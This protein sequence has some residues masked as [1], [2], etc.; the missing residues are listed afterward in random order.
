MDRIFQTWITHAAARDEAKCNSLAAANHESMKH[1]INFGE[2]HLVCTYTRND[3]M[4]TVLNIKFSERFI[5]SLDHADIEVEITTVM[6]A[7]IALFFQSL[8]FSLATLDLCLIAK[9][10]S[11]SSATGAPAPERSRTPRSVQS[12]AVPVVLSRN[13]THV[14]SL[15]HMILSRNGYAVWVRLAGCR[16]HHEMGVKPA[17]GR[18]RATGGRPNPEWFDRR[19]A[20]CASCV[21]QI[22]E[23]RLRR[24]RVR[25][26][27]GRSRTVATGPPRGH[28]HHDPLVVVDRHPVPARGGGPAVD[29]EP[30]RL[31]PVDDDLR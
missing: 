30:E 13:S 14:N 25:R 8:F 22:R 12:D 4:R 29:G 17:G 23:A 3:P 2:T 26:R 7:T 9:S 11:E 10:P 20:G 18:S 21:F 31:V 16:V 1:L 5:S 15:L 6:I 24:A 28:R 19:T 27:R